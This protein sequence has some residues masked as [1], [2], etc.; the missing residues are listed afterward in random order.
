MPQNLS[1]TLNVQ[2]GTV[3]K[4]KLMGKSYLVANLSMIVPGVL[5]GS[6]GKLLYTTEEINKSVNAWNGVPL[7]NNHPIE[8]GK[9]VS[10]RIPEVLEKYAL[11]M[12]L[13]AKGGDKLR[14]EG[15]FDEER[16]KT[17]SPEVYERLLANDKIELSTGLSADITNSAGVTEKGE[18][19]DGVV[20]NFRPDHLAVLPEQTG[21]CS[22][23]RGCGV[24]NTASTEE[25]S[26]SLVVTVW[27]ALKGLFVKN[28]LSHENI[29]TELRRLLTARFQPVTS[30][31]D[32]YNDLWVMDVFNKYVVYA[33]EDKYWKLGYSVKGNSV[34]LSE[35]APEEVTQVTRY[36]TTVENS[37]GGLQMT[38]E[39]RDALIANL[40][41]TCSCKDREVLN[42]LSDT[43]LEKLAAVQ[44]QNES[45]AAAPSQPVVNTQA[46]AKV[47][48]P[49]EVLEVI[50]YV[51]SLK[52][53]EKDAIINRLV[54][55]IPEG[56]AR[57]KAA[58]GYKAMDIE[59]LTVIAN[60]MTPPQAKNAGSLKRT[61]FSGASADVNNASSQ[62]GH[63]EGHLEVPVMNYGKE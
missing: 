32:R 37:N 41:G 39:Q 8:N 58:Q 45:V 48:L 33:Y 43:M 24:N 20:T 62:G 35:D 46:P 55:G 7:T 30:N 18:D 10:A 53:R 29:R 56:D 16:T 38:K 54:Q 26:P 12:V 47:E 63:V 34:S 2:T 25:R 61:D 13:N 14:A 40:G 1:L 21:A 15:W 44:K 31:V 27:N 57:T 19:Y 22:I 4:E 36:E 11:G 5:P 23:E 59:A 42:G 50:N 52:T 6:Q 60:S 49:S 17:I 28:E 9:P 3:R 51:N